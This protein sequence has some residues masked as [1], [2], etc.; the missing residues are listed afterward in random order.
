MNY[1]AHIYLSGNNKEI[2]IGNF[3]SDSVRGN[4]YKSF[5]KEIQKGILLHREIDTFTD[6]HEIFRKS[7][8]RLHKNYGHYSGVIVD[9]FYDH[10]LAKNWENYSDIPLEEFTTSFYKVLDA[11]FDILPQRVQHLMPYLVKDN[12]LLNYASIEGISRVLQGMSR[13]TKY[14]SNMN[15]ATRELKKYNDLFENEFRLFFKELIEF[16]NAKLKEI[17]QKL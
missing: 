10:F 9:I 11:N 3:I 4:K 5:P 7:T 13:R 17:N 16:S 1:L 6:A 15:L 14:N 8:K 12:W 2:A